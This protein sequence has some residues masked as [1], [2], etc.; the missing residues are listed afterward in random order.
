MHIHSS[1]RSI[2]AYY[3][4]APADQPGRRAAPGLGSADYAERC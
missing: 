1:T 2:I 4:S 3:A